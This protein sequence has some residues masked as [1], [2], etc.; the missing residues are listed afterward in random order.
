[1]KSR[2]LKA[3]LT[4]PLVPF[5]A[6]AGAPVSNKKAHTKQP[7]LKFSPDGKFRIL[8]LTDIHEVDPEMDDDENRDIP[9]D[10]SAE[11]V[12]VITKSIE[13]TNPDLIV[14]GGDNISG[15]WEEFTYDYISKTIEKI[16]APIRERNIPFAVVFGN[17]D[18]EIC[19][20]FR[21]FQM[22]LYM[23]YDNFIGSLNAEEMY[24][25]G[26]N[27]IL[28][29]SSKSAKPA[30]NI[31]LVDSN[32]YPYNENGERMSGYDCVH[33]SQLDWYEKT[34]EKLKI[35]N[36][37]KPLPSI[38][39][40]H[41]PVIQEND[42]V[43]ETTVDNPDALYEKGEN[44]YYALK[45]EHKISGEMKELPSPPANGDRTQFELWKKHGD[46]KAAF[47]GHDHV[48]DFIIEIDGIKL[49]QTFSAGYHTYGDKRGG[50]LIVLDENEP[51]NIYTESFVIDRITDTQF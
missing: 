21:E 27:N 14:F 40:Q 33:K 28:I 18:S 5:A 49:V 17:H 34:A 13:R 30:Y 39:F 26:N 3:I 1:M 51:D 8:H 16:T 29:N 47:F 2:F 42:A 38:L 6:A 46:V 31:W 24:G 15:Y 45:K 12:N 7:K 48:N 11:A 41:I 9:R 19:K 10:K 43:E 23:Q 36:G 35:E 50:R 22:M 20:N 4:A 37:G 25:C 32:D 44:K